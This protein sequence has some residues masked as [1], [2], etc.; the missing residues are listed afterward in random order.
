VVPVSGRVSI[1]GEPLADAF[2]RFIPSGTDMAG[3]DSG[4]RTDAEGKFVLKAADGRDGAIVG[5]HRVEI[6]VDATGY[7]V[8]QGV[9]E[10]DESI[11]IDEDAMQLHP[12]YNSNS[13]LTFEVPSGGTDQ[14]NFLLTTSGG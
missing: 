7:D 2:V 11:P 8:S 3:L 4:A 6:R 10:S 9:S 1:E 5:T 12:N 14:A 13:Q